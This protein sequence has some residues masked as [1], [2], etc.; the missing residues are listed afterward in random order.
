MA[1]HPLS[2]IYLSISYHPNVPSGSA[3]ITLPPTIPT[4]PKQ[5]NRSKQRRMHRLQAVVQRPAPSAWFPR[6][7]TCAAATTSP[8]RARGIPSTWDRRDLGPRPEETRARPEGD[9]CSAAACMSADAPIP[10]GGLHAGSPALDPGAHAAR[11]SGGVHLCRAGA[12]RCRRAGGGGT[13]PKEELAVPL[14][15]RA[16]PMCR[17]ASGIVFLLP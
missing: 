12:G 6:P 16:S 4:I 14:R 3:F 2:V 11:S 9:S 1:S 5:K 7:A 17:L 15:L 8:C 10:S 13:A